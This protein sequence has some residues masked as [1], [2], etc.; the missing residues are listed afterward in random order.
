MNNIF[1]YSMKVGCLFN[2]EL[3]NDPRTEDWCG[4]EECSVFTKN[5]VDYAQTNNCD[6]ESV[7]YLLMN[8]VVNE[9]NSKDTPAADHMWDDYC[10]GFLAGEFFGLP[11]KENL[12]K[13]Q[14][15][16]ILWEKASTYGYYQEVL[17]IVSDNEKRKWNIIHEC[18]T[19][20]GKPSQW[21]LEINHSKYG[22]YCWINDMGEYFGVEVDYGSNCFTEIARCKSLSS[23]KRWVTMNLL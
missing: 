19:D 21:C 4:S 7:F 3:N 8:R 12:S 2:K 16:E 18:D 5:I 10:R 15:A 1:K 20:D 17:T 6:I 23:A 14:K 9:I 13:V 22:K 11:T